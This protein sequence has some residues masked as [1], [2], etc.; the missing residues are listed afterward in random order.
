M[1][2]AMQASWHVQRTMHQAPLDREVYGADT[3][4]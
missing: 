3:F 2:A 4:G 1:G